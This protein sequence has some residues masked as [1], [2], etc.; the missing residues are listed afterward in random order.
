MDLLN[1]LLDWLSDTDDLIALALVV[2]A[3]LTVAL[4]LVTRRQ[5]MLI[6]ES[7][8]IT[9]RALLDLE[10]AHI[11]AAFPDPV[12]RNAAE[13]NVFIS[14]TNVGRSAGVIRG[15]FFKFAEPDALPVKP[16]PK[17]YEE[18][19]TDTVLR[20]SE[21]WT[22]L[23]PFKL[24]SRQEGQILLRRSSERGC[25]R[26]DVAQPL[27]LRGLERG[28]AESAIFPAGRRRPLQRRD[29]GDLADARFPR[30]GFRRATGVT[31]WYGRT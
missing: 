22:G 12:D 31:R 2:I 18:R 20:A 9:E 3:V 6:K 21:S 5:A 16:P 29:A 14:L 7:I 28:N 13:W 24:P 1:A 11:A 8:G 17:G 30:P 27:C 10:R 19:A 26:P 25:V 23:P 15:V 4:A